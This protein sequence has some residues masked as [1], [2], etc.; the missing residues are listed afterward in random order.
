M[1]WPTSKWCQPRRSQPPRVLGVRGFAGG[2]PDLP[3][4]GY[5]LTPGE[6]TSALKRCTSSADLLLF[7]KEHAGT[8]NKIHIAAAWGCAK[9]NAARGSDGAQVVEQMQTLTLAHVDK[10]GVREIATVLNAIATLRA[11]GAPV[12][13]SA[14]AG[15]ELL[16]ALL[17][18]LRG[19]AP[20]MNAIQVSS[21]LWSLA[22]L[23]A[24]VDPRTLDA[25]LRQLQ[26][27]VR[28]MNEQGVANA[29]WALATLRESVPADTRD[30]L[31][32]RAAQQA[33]TQT[34]QGVANILWAL[35]SW[36]GGAPDAL[37]GAL[38]RAAAARA[39]DLKPQ[40]V[41]NVLW[42]RPP[43]LL[44]PLP[45]SLLYTHSLPTVAPTRVPTVHSLPPYQVR[46]AAPLARLY[47]MSRHTGRK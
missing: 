13:G 28:D 39:A 16:A 22:K 30:A 31:L 47:D 38:A 18:R 3:R 44:L 40:E 36:G 33:A 25:L 20:Q 12:A 21:A 32:A 8:F 6:L 10:L 26:A 23:R 29:L 1:R 34:P 19:A 11:A 46:P 42:A 35:A 2:S 7:L 27:Q 4:R 43:P 9:R 24:A 17:Q 41:A 37:V 14:G 5:G 45:V 15:E